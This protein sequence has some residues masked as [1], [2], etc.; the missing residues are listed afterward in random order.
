MRNGCPPTSI[1]CACYGT[2]V[3]RFTVDELGQASGVEL[4]VHNLVST[5]PGPSDPATLLARAE[6][7]IRDTRFP[8]SEGRSVVVPPLG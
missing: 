8:P 4:V 2:A 5:Q 3:W 6:E 1:S 7:L